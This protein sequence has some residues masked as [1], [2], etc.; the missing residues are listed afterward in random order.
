MTVD[1]NQP[2]P[3][4]QQQTA[5]VPQQGVPAVQSQGVPQV[6]VDPAAQPV[7]A[8]VPAPASGQEPF[9]PKHRYDE[10]SSRARQLE[11]NNRY[12]AELINNMVQQQRAVTNQNQGMT[13]EDL[14]VD[15]ETYDAA[16]RIAQAE[17]QRVGAPIQNEMASMRNQIE[18]SEFLRMHPEASPHIRAIKEE[19]V[20]TNNLNGAQLDFTHAWLSVRDNLQQQ[21]VRIQRPVQHQPQMIVQNPP[22]TPVPQ[23]VQPQFQGQA[24]TTLPYYPQVQGQQN[25]AYPSQAPPNYQPPPP[26]QPQYQPPQPQYAPQPPI[27]PQAPAPAAPYVHPH[28]TQSVESLESELAQMEAQLEAG[29]QQGQVL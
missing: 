21:G 18:Q 5:Q 3:Q 9:I 15:Q 22:Q 25:G 19:I 8:G 14:N 11:E 28:G 2:A 4:V 6:P 1:I 17:I 16:R 13:P 24:P 10:V 20:Q 29:F 26:M 23:T 27:A 12:Q 7:P